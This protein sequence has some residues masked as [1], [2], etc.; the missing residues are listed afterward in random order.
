M[1]LICLFALKIKE[2][3]EEEEEKEEIVV[4]AVDRAE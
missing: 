2:E 4:M 1:K 3:E